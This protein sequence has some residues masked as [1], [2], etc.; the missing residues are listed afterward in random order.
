[1]TERQHTL[2]NAGY[3]LVQDVFDP[4]RD[5]A[6]VFEDWNLILDDI[7][8]DLADEGL[9]ESTYTGLPF[10]ERLVEICADSGRTF[11]E[12][13]DITLPQHAIAADTPLN[14]PDSIF[15]L[16]T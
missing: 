5:F 16:L 9:I 3:V 6:P 1:M 13:F 7:A 2:N 10:P 14:L 12:Q 8:A 15:Q 4:E 11:A